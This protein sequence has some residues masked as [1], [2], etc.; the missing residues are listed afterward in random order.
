MPTGC[1]R[2]SAGLGPA[3]VEIGGGRFT[4]EV[5][6]GL[7]VPAAC[8]KM[9]VD[10]AEAEEKLR[11]YR[12]LS[13]NP[14]WAQALGEALQ[15]EEK[16]EPAWKEKSLPGDYLGWEWFDVHQAPT[17]L[18][19]MVRAGLL[20]I[21]SSSRSATH[22]RLRSRELIKEALERLSQP[23]PV[24]QAEFPGDLFQAIVGHDNIKAI[25]QMA[26]KAQRPAHILMQGPPA[27]AKTLF[28]MEL[29][30]LPTSY[31]CLAQT[32]TSAGLA[33]LLFLYQPGYLLI[34]EVDRLDGQNVGVLNS[35]MATGVISESKFNKTRSLELDTRVL[36][37]GIRVERL[38]K[39]LLSRFIRLRFEPYTQA[40]FQE[41]C[42]SVLPRE[43][44]P[45]DLAGYIADQ[46]WSI[47]GQNADLREAVAVARIAGGERAQVEEVIRTLK[48]HG[49]G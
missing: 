47:H 20:D 36:A 41:V 17:T 25:V 34:D 16:E 7:E 6:R 38:P 21:T 42:E 28:L 22:Y 24:K 23:S 40:Q 9:E 3:R 13:R 26:I 8:V 49:F 48:K 32:L 31:Y 37:A 14:E 30:R 11:I 44:C 33:D 18:H 19:A 15:V 2:G 27:S 12:A 45:G 39:D 35:L 10:M 1:W 5:A 46:V 29:A 4:V 43:G